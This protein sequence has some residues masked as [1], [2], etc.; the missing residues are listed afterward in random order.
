[1]LMLK[2]GWPLL[3]LLLLLLD[4]R[5]APAQH[6]L[7]MHVARSINSLRNADDQQQFL[8]GEDAGACLDVAAAAAAAA[9][10]ADFADPLQNS[11]K[12][13]L[14]ACDAAH[15]VMLCF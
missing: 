6:E 12:K 4:V 13:P 3:L 11:S 15:Q 8:H 10:A 9:S 2:G 5:L 7:L 14:H 1:M